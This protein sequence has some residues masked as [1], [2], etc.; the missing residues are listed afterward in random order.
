MGMMIDVS[1]LQSL[2]ILCGILVI[3]VGSVTDVNDDAPSKAP[4][5]NDVIPVIL[6]DVS[7]LQPLKVFRGMLVMLVGSVTDTNDDAPLNT[8]SPR[9]I[10]V[11]GITIETSAVHP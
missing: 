4:S 7:D 8:A 9:Y 10:T 11:D 2:K 1:S 3:V 6:I 5:P